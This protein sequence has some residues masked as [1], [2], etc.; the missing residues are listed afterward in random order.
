MCSSGDKTVK[1]TE[2]AQADINK[3]LASEMQT[4]FGQN[5]ALFAQL[6]P[7][8]L[9]LMGQLQNQFENPQ[10]M[11]PAAL[12]AA[13]TGATDA[14]AAQFEAASRNANAVSA[15]HGGS[16]L[17]SGVTSQI[18]GQIAAQGAQ[19]ESGA[20]NQITLANEQLT[21][22]NKWQALQGE[23]G[24]TGELENLA[25]LRNPVNYANAATGAAN[26]VA[27]LG[28]AYLASTQAGWQNAAGIISGVAGLGTAAIGGYGT[29][30][31]K[32]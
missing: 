17:P 11:S 25:S 8:L 22:S 4:T 23:F 24:A 9:S 10:G 2:L 20:Q 18:A 27:G 21:Q 19:A 14:N 7:Q 30:A 3:Q 16:T 6:S 15:A 32:K 5:Q 1:A 31:G 12:T 28:Q 13:R 29:V 26:S